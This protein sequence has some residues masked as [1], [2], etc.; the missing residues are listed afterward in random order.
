MA[1]EDT[2]RTITA[3]EIRARFNL[4][5]STTNQD[6]SAALGFVILIGLA[7]GVG[8]IVHRVTRHKRPQ[9]QPE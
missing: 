6:G 9:D 7:I 1:D 5:S 3:D 8:L 4:G 2:K